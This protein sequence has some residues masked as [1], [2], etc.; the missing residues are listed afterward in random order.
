MTFVTVVMKGFCFYNERLVPKFS[1]WLRV[2]RDLS[3]TGQGVEQVRNHSR[4]GEKGG[5]GGWGGGGIP[6]TSKEIFVIY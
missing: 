3:S 2:P 6:H 4:W 5:G 1:V